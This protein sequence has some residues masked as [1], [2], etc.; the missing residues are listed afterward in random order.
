MLFLYFLN[1]ICL[2]IVLFKFFIEL[3][4]SLGPV[5]QGHDHVET[6]ITYCRVNDMNNIRLF[7]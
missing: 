2:I 4:K 6:E 7:G 1:N 3:K 5:A